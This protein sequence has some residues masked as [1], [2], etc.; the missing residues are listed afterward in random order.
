LEDEDHVALAGSKLA[1]IEM[2]KFLTGKDPQYT[3]IQCGPNPVVLDGKSVTFGDNEP[4]AGSTLDF[5]EV[6]KLASSPWGRGTPDLTTTADADGH[7]R[8]ELKRNVQYEVRV[9]GSD[10]TLLGYGYPIPLQR[11]NYLG[12]FLTESTNPTVADSTTKRVVRSPNHVGLVARY[13][14]GALRPDWNNSLKIDGEEVLNAE[15]APR[16]A[17]RVGLFIYDA[18]QNGQSDLGSVF[19]TSFIGATDVFL[20]ASTPRWM[21][22]RGPTRRAEAS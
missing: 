4:R 12:R 6:G 18:N 19:T 1:F 13:V 5:F 2:Y 10:G 11:S 3:T 8:V 7:F 9:T 22:S 14:A 21:E 15:N 20:D 17:S 16:N